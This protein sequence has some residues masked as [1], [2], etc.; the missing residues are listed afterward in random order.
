M[1]ERT[2]LDV[3]AV[4]AL[5]TGER[6]RDDWTD[7]DRAWASR[8]AAEVVGEHASP[9]QF[10]GRR[11]TLAL[12]RLGERDARF[13]R[14]TRALEWRPW[15]GHAA[16]AGALVLGVAVDRIGGA[17]TINLL[18]P[19]V[20]LLLA[21]NLAVY[22]MLA[23]AP[24]V[25]RRPGE[26]LGALRAALA[27]FASGAASTPRL[28]AAER[29]ARYAAMAGDWARLSAPLYAARAARILHFAAAALA[30]G[31][32]AGMYVRGLAFE[33]RA[34]WESTFL[35]ASQV[36]A[37]LAAALAPGVWL[38]GFRVPDVAQV[39]A[40]RAPATE[41]AAAW[42]H[43]IAATVLAVVVVPRIVLG[44]LAAM[45]ERRRATRLPVPFA[46]PYF[47]RLL[48]GFRGGAVRVRVVP[49]SYTPGAPAQ[50]GLEAIVAR[51]F[52]GSAAIL[53][54]APVAYGADALT[55]RAGPGHAIALFNAT[56]TPERDVHGAFVEM[57]ARD[58]Q[59]TAPVIALVDESAFR[60]RWPGDD[61][62]LAERRATWRDA[63]TPTGAAVVF[64]DLATPD[65]AAAE[66]ALDAALGARE[67]MESS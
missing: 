45:V 37:L 9:E 58:T 18:A 35:D 61:A 63:L 42:L 40:I 11:A 1:D 29:N 19:P 44:L 53:V 65:L 64:A 12:E 54:D 3:T 5:E 41:N 7:A 15:V 66:A 10:V 21:W 46:E 50:A 62:R 8:A 16:I 23:F 49:Y 67:G 28:R 2:A 4:R 56:A 20:F 32:I 57:L 6:A 14:A 43:L 25:R 55:A 22:V 24:F 60:A 36:R 51:G 39:T 34:T 52:G 33:Y 30:L 47:R 31:V 13:V 17:Q 27:R 38:T 48:R 59:A 26:T